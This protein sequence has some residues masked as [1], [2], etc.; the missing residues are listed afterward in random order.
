MDMKEL[1]KERVRKMAEALEKVRCEW[2]LDV[3]TT[4]KNVIDW[5]CALEAEYIATV[6]AYIEI[7]LLTE[8]ECNEVYTKMLNEKYIVLLPHYHFVKDLKKELVRYRQ[9]AADS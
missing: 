7:G 1:A 3:N 8:A 5:F 2:K 9:I 4:F 6:D